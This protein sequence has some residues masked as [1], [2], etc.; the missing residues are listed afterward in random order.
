MD[1]SVTPVPPHKAV[2]RGDWTQEQVRARILELGPWFHNMRLKG[3]WTAPE[4]F[5]GDYP[6]VKWRAY[7]D[8]IPHD[9]RGKTV[10]DIG[11]NGGFFSLE[12][13]RRGA[14]RVLGIDADDR[15]LEQARFAADVEGL[16]IEFRH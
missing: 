1:A 16:N 14:D 12:M 11:C 2:Q 9:L 15:Y 4:H 6:N 10:L 13:K 8:A 3:V 7:A 5:L